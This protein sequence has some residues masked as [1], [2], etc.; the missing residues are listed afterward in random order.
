M[1]NAPSM[2]STQQRAARELQRYSAFFADRGVEYVGSTDTIAHLKQDM[3]WT[4][5]G[6]VVK[7]PHRGRHKE[8]LI[9][10]IAATAYTSAQ[11][12]L[13]GSMMPLRS[14]SEPLIGF[15]KTAGDPNAFGKQ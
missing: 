7:S 4:S 2:E 11:H 12:H 1:Y 5:S 14:C 6:A 10:L 3:S 9:R 15:S 8:P 13:P